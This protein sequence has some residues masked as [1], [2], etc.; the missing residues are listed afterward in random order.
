MSVPQ[1]ANKIVIGTGLAVPPL[2]NEFLDYRKYLKAFYE[3]KREGTKN[4]IRPYNYTHF[5]VAADIKSPSY[6]RL[7]IDG[8][9]NL[10]PDMVEK[11]IK[12][13]GLNRDEAEEFRILVRFNQCSDPAERN[14]ELRALNDYRVKQKLRSGEIDQ[15]TWDKVPNWITWVIYA[16]LDQSGVE[17][18][19]GNLRRLLKD[20]ASE[21]EIQHA[22]ES[23]LLSGEVVVDAATGRLKKTRALMESAD[24][25]PVALVRKLQGELMHLGLESLYED[26]PTDRE[27]GSLTISMTSKEF[28]EL[29]FQLRKL[30]KSLH[31]E[32][33]VARLAGPGERVY[34][35]NFQ[36]F[37]LTMAQKPAQAVA[38]TDENLFKNPIVPPDIIET[39][40]ADKN[41]SQV[42]ESSPLD[43]S[44]EG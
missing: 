4:S 42:E 29:K 22:L 25:I 43:D 18:S 7:I 36:L 26:A 41:L 24:D 2:L 31:K 20:K 1:G 5:S 17:F 16:M 15:K 11:F 23:L 12:A 33:S 3:F 27:F 10:S 39:P 6:L 34:Q 13:L 44:N 35:V 9:R 30:R 19:V 37:P 8:K 38:S 21:D 14:V 28:E 40:E 32:N